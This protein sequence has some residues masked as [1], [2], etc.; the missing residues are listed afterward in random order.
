MVKEVI[1]SAFGKTKITRQII[2]IVLRIEF[3]LCLQ[4]FW[5]I[6]KLCQFIIN[7]FIIRFLLYLFIGYFLIYFQGSFSLI[8]IILTI[9]IDLI[10]ILKIIRQSFF[11]ISWAFGLFFQSFDFLRWMI[12]VNLIFII[13]I[14]RAILFRI[15]SIINEITFK[16][17]LTRASFLN[18][19]FLIKLIRGSSF[20]FLHPPFRIEIWILVGITAFLICNFVESPFFALH[21]EFFLIIIIFIIRWWI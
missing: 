10:L 8:L 11:K 21:F 17:I 19:L 6:C 3:V 4:T 5:I 16:F 12:L 9:I 18:S 20:Q 1:V 15:R 14:F 7:H 13:W 2:F